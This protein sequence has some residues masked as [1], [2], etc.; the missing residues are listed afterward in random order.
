ML[1]SSA[2]KPIAITTS[3]TFRSAAV[4]SMRRSN[5]LTEK[6]LRGDRRFSITRTPRS[7]LPLNGYLRT[8]AAMHNHRRRQVSYAYPFCR[9]G[10]VAGKLTVS[11]AFHLHLQEICRRY[12][13]DGRREMAVLVQP[14]DQRPSGTSRRTRASR[15]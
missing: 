10:S 6:R 15:L 11:V 1:I 14:A 3:R 4:R 13:T 8:D 5:A 9:A 7:V 12:T 2:A